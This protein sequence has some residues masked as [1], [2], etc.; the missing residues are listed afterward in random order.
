MKFKAFLLMVIGAFTIQAHAV[1][2]DIYGDSASE[3][4]EELVSQLKLKRTSMGDSPEA[5]CYNQSYV[6]LGNMTCYE[7][8]CWDESGESVERLWLYRCDLSDVDKNEL[9]KVRQILKVLE[10]SEDN[11]VFKD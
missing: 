7:A 4:Y 2:S 3:I 1:D 6:N 11:E 10:L 8:H 9:G 5:G